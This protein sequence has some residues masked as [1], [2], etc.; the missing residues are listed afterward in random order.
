MCKEWLKRAMRRALM[1]RIGLARRPFEVF[2]CC[3]HNL[4]FLYF[5]TVRMAYV[6]YA[7]N[8]PGRFAA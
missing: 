2:P 8:T 7:K 1:W 5:S 4:S 3:F 6:E